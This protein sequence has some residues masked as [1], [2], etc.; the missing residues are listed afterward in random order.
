MEKKREAQSC[1]S[2]LVWE[3]NECFGFSSPATHTGQHQF[4]FQEGTPRCSELIPSLSQGTGT[5]PGTG[6]VGVGTEPG[7]GGA[8]T[9]TEGVGTGPE[10]GGA[11]TGESG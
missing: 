3:E 2:Q 8:G 9:E 4:S 6:G 7:T 10:I 11:R 1:W 5:E